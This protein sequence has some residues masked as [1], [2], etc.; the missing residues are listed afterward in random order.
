[1]SE[2]GPEIIGREILRLTA[3]LAREEVQGKE[4]RKAAQTRQESLRW[5]LHAALTGDP[6]RPPGKEVEEFLGALKGQ[7]G[8]N[9]G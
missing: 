1:M 3:E 8:G 5:A 6:S 4:R 2:Q 7:E 9:R